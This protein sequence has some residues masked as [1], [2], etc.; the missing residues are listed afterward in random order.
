MDRYETTKEE[1]EV[2]LKKLTFKRQMQ[3][4]IV[5]GF[6]IFF[7]CTTFPFFNFTHRISDTI[8]LLNIVIAVVAF[9]DMGIAE[10]GIF[11][12]KSVLKVLLLNTVLVLAGMGCRY[13]LEFGEISNT[14]N[15]TVLNSL[16][17][18]VVAATLS[19]LGWYNYRKR[20]TGE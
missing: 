16:V 10:A 20:L 2:M 19:T 14:Y 5:L 17:H 8:H 13:L 4:G 7:S 9:W 15:F 1:V 12:E 6:V 11:H 18:I 3:I